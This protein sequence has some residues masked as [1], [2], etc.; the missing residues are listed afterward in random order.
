MDKKK[1]IRLDELLSRAID[2]GPV[3]FDADKWKREHPTAWQAVISRKTQATSERTILRLLWQRKLV[4]L[5]TAAVVMVTIV[6][7][8]A[9]R[10]RPDLVIAPA[11]ASR[12]KSPAEMMSMLSLSLAYR[13][14]GMESVDEQCDKALKLLGH[15]PATISTK[16]LLNQDNGTRIEESKS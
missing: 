10:R 6:V 2:S 8:Y 14:G 1:E 7:L 13:R 9:P 12:E 5:T 16:E 15:K 3:H 4:W 11:V